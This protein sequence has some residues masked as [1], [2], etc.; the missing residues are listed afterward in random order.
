M[1]P[2]QRWGNPSC[3]HYKLRLFLSLLTVAGGAARKAQA[4]LRESCGR[5]IFPHQGRAVYTYGCLEYGPP[6]ILMSIG[7]A[8]IGGGWRRM[9][10]RRIQRYSGVRSAP[11]KGVPTT[12]VCPLTSPICLVALGHCYVALCR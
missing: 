7:Q 9:L 8:T 5:A 12:H 10:R 4:C 2:W 3:H 1:F 11:A 6:R